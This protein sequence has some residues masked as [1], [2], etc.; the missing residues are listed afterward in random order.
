MHTRRMSKNQHF[1]HIA[2]HYGC[3]FGMECRYT[4]FEFGRIST[5]RRRG[6]C[7]IMHQVIG[8]EFGSLALNQRN[9]AQNA[10]LPPIRLAMIVCVNQRGQTVTGPQIAVSSNHTPLPISAG[11]PHKMQDMPEAAESTA[12][13]QGKALLKLGLCAASSTATMHPL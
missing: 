13:Q 10:I 3:D 4:N 9:T 11:P 1:I 6:I 12:S 5:A 2:I 8:E 7:V